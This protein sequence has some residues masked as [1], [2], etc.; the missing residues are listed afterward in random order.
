MHAL[1]FF[2]EQSRPDRDTY[3]KLQLENLVAPSLERQF[4]MVP[5]TV[6]NEGTFNIPYDIG[7]LM[8]YGSTA[9]AKPGTFTIVRRSDN[10]PF[11][12]NRAGFAQS[13]LQALNVLYRCARAPPV[14]PKPPTPAT[15]APPA[16]TSEPVADSRCRGFAEMGMCD[17]R[18]ICAV[19]NKVC[20]QAQGVKELIRDKSTPR[21]CSYWLKTGYCNPEKEGHY[22][23]SVLCAKTCFRAKYPAD[24]TCQSSGGGK[25]R[26]GK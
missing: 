1:G 25:T 15:P 21:K 16:P 9:F 10:Q 19:C 26:T 4:R 17:Y 13:D 3:I 7:S 18:Q 11:R 24:A 20:A 2:H 5:E 6:L 12:S 8:H 23:M 14:T 22:A